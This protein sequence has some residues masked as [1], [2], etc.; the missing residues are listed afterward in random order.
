GKYISFS[1][2]PKFQGKNLKRLLPEF[3]GVQ[4]PG[5]DTCVADAS[6]RNLWVKITSDGKSNKEADWVFTPEAGR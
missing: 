6:G 2:G 4:A 3:P 1:Y 5:W